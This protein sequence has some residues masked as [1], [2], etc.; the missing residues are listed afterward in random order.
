MKFLFPFRRSKP[1]PTPVDLLP[2][3]SISHQRR[4]ADP[5]VANEAQVI[6]RL[7][8]LIAQLKALGIQNRRNHLIQSQEYINDVDAPAKPSRFTNLEEDNRRLRDD[9]EEISEEV[10]RQIL[11]YDRYCMHRG[12]DYSPAW[13]EL[14]IE[15]HWYRQGIGMAGAHN[16]EEAVKGFTSTPTNID[17]ISPA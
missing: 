15:L 2:V 7:H 11:A 5:A 1:Q 9:Y 16:L 4:L 13:Q 17:S 3:D 6:A 14:L 8:E 10:E 12:I